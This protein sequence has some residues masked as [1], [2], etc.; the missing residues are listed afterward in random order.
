LPPAAEKQF[1]DIY[2]RFFQG[3]GQTRVCDYAEDRTE[4]KHTDLWQ[5]FPYIQLEEFRQCWAQYGEGTV[6]QKFLAMMDLWEKNGRTIRDGNYKPQPQMEMT[7][8]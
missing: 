1:V 5:G 4:V 3:E 8:I 2:G 7:A 6:D